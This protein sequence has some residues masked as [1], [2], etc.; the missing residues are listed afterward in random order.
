M[1][2]ALAEP[3]IAAPHWPEDAVLDT[4]GDTYR[5]PPAAPEDL[6]DAPPAL[7]ALEA[8]AGKELGPWLESERQ[9]LDAAA[10]ARWRALLVCLWSDLENE[11]GADVALCVLDQMGLEPRCSAGVLL[12][13]DRPALFGPACREWPFDLTLRG[14]RAVEVRYTYSETRGGWL[15]RESPQMVDGPGGLGWGRWV[16]DMGAGKPVPWCRALGDALYYA[17]LGEPPPPEPPDW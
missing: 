7:A 15:R 9:R 14:R 6:P 17:G 1:T 16:A 12:G 8:A 3:L 5:P 13:A 11:L 4:R 2:H 10:D